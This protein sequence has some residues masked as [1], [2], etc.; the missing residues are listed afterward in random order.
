[1]RSRTIAAL[2]GALFVVVC[3]AAVEVAAVPATERVVAQ[4]VRATTDADD[5]VVRSVARPA[6]FDVVRGRVTDVRIEIVGLA[7]GQL[8]VDQVHIEVPEIA[9]LF[10]TPG[11]EGP[12]AFDVEVTDT[13]VGSWLRAVAP[14]VARPT[15]RFAQGQ[16]IVSDERVPFDVRVSVDVVDG[17]IHLTPGA[18]DRRLWNWLGLG[19][20]LPLPSG[21]QIDDLRLIDGR[22]TVRGASNC[23]LDGDQRVV[24]S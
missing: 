9:G 2:A 17:A 5:I 20:D 8:R 22:A 7:V 16:V 18:G 10:S 6:I 12:I 23:V 4:S 14:A 1:V 3:V 13:D 21:L 15:V 11:I 19:L 24:C